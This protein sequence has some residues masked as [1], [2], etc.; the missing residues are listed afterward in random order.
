MTL[1][2]IHISISRVSGCFVRIAIHRIND[3]EGN[4][5]ESIS[6]LVRSNNSSKGILIIGAYK[7][8]NVLKNIWEPEL[9]TL[10]LRSFQRYNHIVL[11]GDLNC[12]LSQPDKSSKEGRV[13][14]DV[15]NG[16]TCQI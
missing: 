15:M 7:P 13:L 2:L 11:L 6:L 8:P 1:S 5:V 10:L 9:N 12:D 16:T 14:L 3:L 4:N